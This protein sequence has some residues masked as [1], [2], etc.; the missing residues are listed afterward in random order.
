VEIEDLY[1]LAL[2]SQPAISPDGGRIVYVLT[3]ADRE[4]DRNVSQ[5]WHVETGGGEPRR[6]TRGLNDSSPAWSPDGTRIAFLRAEDGPAQVWLLPTAGEPEQVTTLPLGAGAPVWSPDGGRIAFAATVD[7]DGREAAPVAIDRLGYKFDGVGLYGTKRRHLHVLDVAT[8]KISRV[9]YGDWHA[10][11]PTWSPDG[12]LLAFSAAQDPDAAMTFRSAAYVVEPGGEPRLV[13]S[14][15]GQ[16][17]PVA[18]TADGGA[19]LVVGR[20]DTAIGQQGLL[21]VP[22]DGGEVVD[23][24][25]PLDRNVM[26]GGPGYPGALPQTIGDTVLFCVR[27]RGCSHLYAW[28]GAARVV[29]GGTGNV[30]SGVDVAGDKIAI[31][32]AT[33]DSYGEVAT[34]DLDGEITV[35]TRHSLDVELFSHEERE[36]TVSDGTVVHGWLLR[37]PSRQGPLPLLLDIHGGPHN[38]WNAA[39]DSV[40][41]Y[42]QV[43]ASR[44]WAVLLLNPPASDGYGEAFYTATLGQWGLI[45]AKHFLEPL[46]DLVASGVADAERLA[47]AG[48]SYGGFMTC[49]LT[50]RDDRFAVAVA[51]GII[52]DATS[53]AGTSDAGYL[54]AQA[55]FAS[56]E[57][58]PLSRVDDV[59]T[60]TLVLHG[61]SDERCPVGQAEQWFTALHERGVRSELVVYPGA[62]HL[63]ILN[64]RPS[65]RADYNQRILDWV[66][67]TPSI[68]ADHWRRRLAEL[69]RKHGVPGAALGILRLDTD[70]VVTVSAG[71]LSKATDVAVTDDSVFQIGSITKVWTTTLVMQ[72]VDEGLVE[73]DAPIA[74]VLPELRLSDPQVA[75]RVTLRHLLTH[76][77]GIDGDVLTDTGRGDDCVARYVEQLELAA[78]NHPLGVTFSYCNAGFV[79]VGRVIEKLTGKSWDA[80]L[81]ERLIQPLGLTHTVTLPE[82]A[83]MLRPAVGHQTV[84]GETRPAPVWGLARSLGPAGLIVSSTADVLA[85]ARPH[86]TG[87]GGLLSEASVKA[88][89]EHQVDVPNQYGLAESWGLGWM[90]FTWDGRQIIGHD[91]NT[92][93]QSSCLRIVPELGLAVTLLM[94]GGNARDLYVELFTEIFGELA[95]IAVPPP[96]EP[97]TRP[98]DV[99][100]TRHLGTYERASERLEIF[101][102]DTG[103]RIR[104]TITGPLAASVPEPVMELDLLPVR[105][106]VFVCRLPGQIGWTSVVFYTLPSGESYLHSHGRATPKVG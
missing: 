61:G 98:V 93:G 40:H 54:L 27:D 76:T 90:R 31:V 5:L 66:T 22:L 30:V 2:P 53:M 46:D 81:R 79:L 57:A 62:S 59:L 97:P 9:T 85:F 15:D 75:K 69:A 83:L 28:D 96:L 17:G 23:L 88:M 33:S 14:D 42:H 56:T 41:L 50:S 8:G 105:E 80:V 94:N 60:P 58:S 35:L 52:A 68:R 12:K 67:Q 63:F 26:P 55:G 11:D 20:T 10:A 103:V 37:D 84:E 6:L 18:W 7:P 43:L 44:G 45:D 73:L 21:W 3:T 89:A 13:G 36:F 1:R 104:S 91:G 49:Y 25:K 99:D 102:G 24:A 77:S 95:D 39:A 38:A 19:L 51:G 34:V 47:V 82:E 65:H 29:V 72:L 48:Y 71:V 16:A 101:Q 64:G 100:A 70:E 4:A 78:L 87:G 74:D 86:L 106:N 92:I 32:L